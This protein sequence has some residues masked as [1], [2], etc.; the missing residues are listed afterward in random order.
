M[1]K[2]SA[3]KR[4]PEIS[5]E[6]LNENHFSL[7]HRWFNALHIQAFYSLRPWT[8]EE[9]RQKLIP[10]IEGVGKMKCYIISIDKTPIG[11]I[12][13][14]PVKN[15]PWDSQ[16]LTDEVI[17]DSAGLDLFIGE[18]EFIGKGL[19][20]QIL[21]A[22]LKS[23]IWSH[24]RYCLADPDVRNA[25]SVRLFKKCG[26][27]EYQKIDS[28]DALQRPVTLQLFIK[29]RPQPSANSGQSHEDF[30]VKA[31]LKCHPSEQS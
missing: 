6:P 2:S 20:S 19:S 26:F 14:Y 15:H 12:Q 31:K 8:I 4:N 24:Y 7:I 17:Q 9:V 11:Y 30:T 18:K 3:Y 22:F 10:Y 1:N 13:C 28:K 21:D 29:R 16:N 23:H 25:A 5:F 27:Q